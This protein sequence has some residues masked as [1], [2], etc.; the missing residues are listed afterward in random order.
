MR[1]I[2]LLLPILLLSQ[3]TLMPSQAATTKVISFQAEGWADNWFSLYIN[4]KKVGEDSIPITT[5]RSFNQTTIKFKASYPFTVGVIAKDY[6][7]NKSGLEYIGQSNQQIGDGGFIL[8][9]RDL[10]TGKIVAATN[11]AWKSLV[12]YKAPT[13]PNCEKSSDPLK[14]CLTAT[15][16]TPT[17]WSNASFKDSS[18][19]KSSEYSESAVG[20]KE[21][22]ND[23]EWSPSA[24]LIWGS[25][26]KLDNTILFRFTVKVS[27]SITSTTAVKQSISSLSV[28]SASAD[29]SGFL[30]RENT[31]DGGGIS[32]AIGWSAGPIGTKSYV[33]IMDTIPGPARP[34]ESES[35][36]HTYLNLYNI[37]GNIRAIDEG[38]LTQGMLG[39]NFKSKAAYEPPCSQ[40][41]GKKD[42]TITVIALSSTL[43]ISPS[44]ATPK[45]I[46]DASKTQI[47]ATGK[48]I[49]HYERR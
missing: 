3:A 44:Q 19:T 38:K 36:D 1:K 5:V 7:E 48:F 4:G 23:I 46:I 42:Y 41:P 13:N 37:P 11:S 12:I 31:C 20:V 21:G 35:A 24:I 28:S 43:N 15:I 45:M 8:Q 40:G 22:Y 27:S 33:V 39:L 30:S 10:S 47:L 17:G 9:I 14:D 6:V 49:A 25:D 2:W 32:P 18:W 16:N 29:S 34:G 26:L